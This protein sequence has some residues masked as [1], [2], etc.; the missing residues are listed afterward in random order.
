MKLQLPE[1]HD[2]DDGTNLH[3]NFYVRPA[4]LKHEKHLSQTEIEYLDKI[5]STVVWPNDELHHDLLDRACGLFSIVHG[6]SI[7]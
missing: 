1:Q 2:A 6:V 5:F 3:L 4:S 7:F